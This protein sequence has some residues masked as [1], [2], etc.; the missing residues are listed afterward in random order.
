MYFFSHLKDNLENLEIYHL[1]E[2]E[3]SKYKTL[4]HEDIK[5]NNIYEYSL[6]I[7]QQFSMDI[8]IC[9]Y[10]VLSCIALNNEESFEIMNKLFKSLANILQNSPENLGKNANTLNAQKRKLKN[11]IEHFIME[12]DKLNL[13][14]ST[15]TTIDLNHTFNLLGEILG[16][17]FKEIRLKQYI[18]ESK[19]TS[20]PIIKQVELQTQNLNIVSFSDR[21]YRIFFNNLAF[22]ILEDDKE[23]L[24]AYAMFVEAMWGRIKT[25]PS[26][27]DENVTQIKYPD[28]NLI[29]I[30]LQ[31]N[32]NE[33]EHIKCFMSNLVL[34]PFWIEGLKFFCEFLQKHKKVNASNLLNVLARNFLLKFKEISNLKFNNGKFMCEEQILNYFLKQDINFNHTKPKINKSKRNNG[35]NEVLIGIN[36]QNHNNSL[37]SN[38]N[39]LIE[40][41]RLFE[42]KNMQNNAKT[43]YIQIKDLME[44][45]LLKDYLSEDYLEIKAKIEKI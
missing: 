4:N 10:F 37:F 13:S 16:C 41:A 36:T 15:Q 11:I 28:K 40:M 33:L 21:E 25:L 43:L 2:D 34:N 27:N 9:N 42:E 24:N 44:K 32:L 23:N 8:R 26:H 19:I 18:Q 45:T 1:L 30:L 20:S 3:M 14:H 38:I 5:W 31:N 6:E 35:I 7:L 17:D 39:A 22:E 29:Q 12:S